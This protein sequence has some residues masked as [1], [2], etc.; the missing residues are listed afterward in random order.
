VDKIL[1]D[2]YLHAQLLNFSGNG[3]F[4]ILYFF[5]K[6]STKKKTGLQDLQDLQ[7]KIKPVNPVNLAIL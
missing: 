4:F 5:L 7:E 6:I 1:N 3:T 2:K